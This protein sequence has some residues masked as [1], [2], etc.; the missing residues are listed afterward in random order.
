MAKIHQ[1]EPTKIIKYNSYIG[2]QISFVQPDPLDPKNA[3][4]DYDYMKAAPFGTHLLT[5]PI[6]ISGRRTKS[7]RELL[8]RLK[9]TKSE[10]C[11]LIIHGVEL[12]YPVKITLGRG[13][14]LEN[15]KGPGL[16]ITKHG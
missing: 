5:I 3:S 4:I 10:V 15:Y 6:K 9:I 8:K 1:F 16:Y 14:R 11:R 13:V 7:Y 2:V 12:P